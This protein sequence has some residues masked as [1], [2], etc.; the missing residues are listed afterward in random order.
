M[1]YRWQTSAA[2]GERDPAFQGLVD[3]DTYPVSYRRLENALIRRS[4]S[5]LHRPGT[6]FLFEIAGKLKGRMAFFPARNDLEFRDIAAIFYT[7]FVDLYNAETEVFIITL[8]APYQEADLGGLEFRAADG[9]LYIVHGDFH[10]REIPATLDTV[11]KSPFRNTATSTAFSA[12]SGERVLHRKRTITLERKELLISSNQYRF[13]F[14]GPMG[15]SPNQTVWMLEDGLVRQV[16]IGGTETEFIGEATDITKTGPSTLWNGPWIPDGVAITGNFTMPAGVQPGDTGVL[17]LNTAS[18]PAF[19][20]ADLGVVFKDNENSHHWLVV[21]ILTTTTATAINMEGAGT[22]GGTSGS[23]RLEYSPQDFDD[24]QRAVLIANDTKAP[25]CTKVHSTIA[26]FDSTMIGGDHDAILYLNGMEFTITT[27]TDS[28]NVVGTSRGDPMFLGVDTTAIEKAESMGNTQ[29]WSFSPNPYHG[30]ASVIDI[31]QN[32]MLLTGYA[33]DPYRMNFSEV[34]HFENFNPGTDN[35]DPFTVLLLDDDSPGGITW[36]YSTDTDLLIGTEKQGPYRISGSPVTPSSVGVARQGFTGSS[37]VPPIQIGES[38][39]YIDRCR[40]CILETSFFDSSQRYESLELNAT[41]GHLFPE[42]SIKEIHYLQSPEKTAFFVLNDGTLISLSRSN[43]HGLLA[44]NKWVGIFVESAIVVPGAT[45]DTLWVVV[46]RTVDIST[47]YYVEIWEDG[48]PLDSKK[49]FTSPA[50]TTLTGLGH[51]EGFTVRCTIDANDDGEYTVVA[52]QIGPI[53]AT[54]TDVEV[55]VSIPFRAI[56]QHLIREDVLGDLFGR[57]EALATV[58][59]LLNDSRGG[60]IGDESP[61][62]PTD[63][64][65]TLADSITS[66]TGFVKVEGLRLDAISP[67]VLIEHDEGTRFEILAV[68]QLYSSARDE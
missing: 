54:G 37:K 6:R 39:I 48:L 35:S 12:R 17:T 60:K 21:E 45:K 50:S 59:V 34:E 32:R 52:G 63:I 66:F 65:Q 3:D 15:Y 49:K 53:S 14:S 28:Q 2:A 62:C 27:V 29:Q 19:T 9:H 67:E 10:T 40:R 64:D 20:T 46:K 25:G 38:V 18:H 58:K 43:Q 47:N 7:N 61:L 16:N 8:A 31:H 24:T 44:F 51:L 57:G 30:F 56:P 23:L 55:G 11:A 1:A 42:G 26:L 41:A 33:R 13:E 5:L 68:G 4:G 22:G 36:A